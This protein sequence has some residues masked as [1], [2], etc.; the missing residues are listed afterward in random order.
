MPPRRSM[1]QGRIK[2]EI[3][4]VKKDKALLESGT[5]IKLVSE[6]DF[7]H[8]YGCIRG[9]PETPYEGGTYELD[10]RIPDSYPFSPPQVKF[11]TRLWH[12]NI[13]SQT[14]AI[15]LDI[16]KDQWQ[17]RSSTAKRCSD[18][19][20]EILFRAAAMTLRTV[21]LSIQALM[22]AAEPDDPQDAVVANQYKVNKAIFELTA[23]HWAQVYANAP[24]DDETTRSC[25]EKVA[26]LVAM[27][28]E[29][30]K[31]RDSLSACSWNVQDAIGR[32][33]S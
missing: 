14:G 28:I 1:A 24:R 8:L 33:Y 22:A 20:V 5:I 3:G 29:E 26:Y 7:T 15:C 21:L 4:E 17:L 10:I 11:T 19:K 13:S 16:L 27:G 23:R 32:I 2:R 6:D 25:D 30:I 18:N 12:P 9:A 31:A